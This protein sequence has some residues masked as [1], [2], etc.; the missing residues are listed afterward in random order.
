MELLRSL[1]FG[2]IWVGFGSVRLQF[3]A[4]GCFDTL[5]I[6]GFCVPQWGTLL[7]LILRV[8][9]GI[10][11]GEGLVLVSLYGGLGAGFKYPA[12]ELV[13][14]GRRVKRQEFCSFCCVPGS[15]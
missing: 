12:K 6:G 9:N 7:R 15:S 1:S 13:F 10:V 3:V 5:F 4:L 14:S 11:G 2:W 8:I